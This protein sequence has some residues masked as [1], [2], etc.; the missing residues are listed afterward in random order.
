[1]ATPRRVGDVLDAVGTDVGLHLH[2]TR[3]TA[4]VNAWTAIERGVTRFDTAV[5]GLGG[6]PFAPSAGG[7]LAT[8]D[9]VLLLD[10]AGIESPAST[11][12]PCWRSDPCSPTSSVTTCRAAWPPPGA[13]NDQ[14][15]EVLWTPPADAWTATAAGRFA[16]AHG[17]DD[18]AALHAWSVDDLDGF[19]PAA[20][21]SPA[22]AG[23]TGPDAIAPAN[24]ARRA[25]VPR[26]H[27]QLRRA[28]ARRRR[29]HVRDDVAVVA[30]SQTRDPIELTWRA[31][32]RRRRPPPATGCAAS[33]SGR[34]PRRRLRPEHPRDARRLP[35]HGVDRGDWSSCAPEFG[36]RSVIDRFA[37]IEPAV[38]V[39]VDGYRYGS[40]DIDRSAEVAE[41]APRS[42]TLR[43]VVHVPYLRPESPA[44]R[45]V[46]WA[47]LVAGA[48]AAGVR[49]RSPPTTRSTCCS[50]PGRP[51]CPKP[52]VHGHGGIVAE[53]L[54]VLTLHQDLGPDDR[55]CWFTTTGWMMWNYLV[56]GLLTGSTIVLF[57]GDPAAPS[58]DTLWDL[59]AD[60]GLTV[61]GVSAPF[62]MACRKAGIAP[63]PG[64]LRWVG[65]T[66]APLPADG[67]R[68]V[69]EAVGVP[70]SSISGGTDV[71]TAFVGSSP[72]VP[73]RAGEISCRLLGCAVEAFTPD[74]RPA[75]A[76]VTGELVITA[77][78][79]SMPV[80]FW[81]DDDGSRYR[82]A[83][84][85]DFP[86]VWRHGDW[87]TFTDDGACVITGRSDATLN[88]GGVRL[89]TSDFYAVVE[90]FAEVAD[91]LVVHLEDATTTAASVSSCCSSPSRRAASST[92]SWPAA[93]AA[94]CAPSCRRATCPTRS[95]PSRRSRARCR[96]RSWRCR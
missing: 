40:Q 51:A 78:M 82:A 86:G 64:V 72:L 83:Y 94:R 22:C 5:G 31:A 25:L 15:G 73:V 17:F 10:D 30:H 43:H 42:P 60:T 3:A 96:A 74:G 19:W 9:L 75:P 11:S 59:A 58:L 7:N 1:M 95:R 24:D 88:R 77:P 27:A 84:F 14:R 66:G 21:S 54:K 62:L 69:D 8:E 23:A 67:F 90:G 87:V 93:S 50:A 39:A 6:S 38:L 16:T 32:R 70:V 33:A 61:F 76:G 80:G 2:D 63:A 45:D 34:R 12:L 28:R 53:H 48:A 57:D 52:I 41:I 44:G 35:R 91:S 47:D 49:R 65:S 29:L 55:F 18:Y 68:W 79:P 89:G 26:R 36:V 4:L 71:C 81:G 46:S 56:S 13:V 37:Q 92:T 85:E 20:T